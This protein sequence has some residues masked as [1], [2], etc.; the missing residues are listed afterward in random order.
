M[1]TLQSLVLNMSLKVKKSSRLAKMASCKN[2][3]LC[4][5]NAHISSVVVSEAV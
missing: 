5:L 1:S 2:D 3:F 4:T